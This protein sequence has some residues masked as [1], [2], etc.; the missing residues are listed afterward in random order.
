[1]IL[2][3]LP[4]VWFGGDRWVWAGGI[5]SREVVFSVWVLGSRIET[6]YGINRDLWVVSEPTSPT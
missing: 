6:T 5:S 4:R 1:M 3:E 2:K